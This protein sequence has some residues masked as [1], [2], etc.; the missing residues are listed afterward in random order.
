MNWQEHHSWAGVF[1]ATL[2]PFQEDESIDKAG[3]QGYIRELANVDGVKGLVR[4]GHTGEMRHCVR[5]S[6]RV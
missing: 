2:C 3:L 5:A 1:P 6:V 4:N